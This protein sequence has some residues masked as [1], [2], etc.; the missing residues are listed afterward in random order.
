MDRNKRA[1][2]L[3][4]AVVFLA[5]SIPSTLLLQALARYRNA[6]AGFEPPVFKP[7][8]VR[9]TPRQEAVPASLANLD[10]AAF[11]L[12]APKAKAVALIGDFNGWKAGTLP[13]ARKAAGDWEILLPLPPGRYRY[14]F[15]VDGQE[16]PDPAA[17]ENEP[18]SGRTASVRVVR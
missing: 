16:R 2:W 18:V 1:F 17:K 12:K 9:F 15:V 13:L 7:I 5:A 10:F 3:F 6:L 11:R 8:Q 4:I 14:L